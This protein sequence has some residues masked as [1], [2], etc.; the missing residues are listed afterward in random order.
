[1]NIFEPSFNIGTDSSFDII[2]WNI[3][4]FPKH[5]STIKYLLELIPIMK[6]DVI[7]LQ[8]IEN[9]SMFNYLKNELN[10]YNGIITNSAAYNINLA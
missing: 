7:A 2:T 1:M 5:D 6:P 10:G 8:E 9:E 3:Q 4:N